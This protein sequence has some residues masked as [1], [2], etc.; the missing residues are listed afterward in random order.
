MAAPCLR[1]ALPA[2]GDTGDLHHFVIG[3][4]GHITIKKRMTELRHPFLYPQNSWLRFAVL[5]N[6]ATLYKAAQKCIVMGMP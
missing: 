5:Q 1:P 2:A 6:V 4:A 3:H